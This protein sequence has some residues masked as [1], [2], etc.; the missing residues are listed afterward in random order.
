MLILLS[1]TRKKLLWLWIGFTA[2]LIVLLFVQTVAGKFENIETAVWT[3]AFAHLLPALALLFV[4]VLLNRNPS[5]VLFQATFRAVYAGA[6]AYLLLLLLTLLA[7][8]FATQNWSIE[9]YFARSYTW[10]MPF[11]AVLLLAFSFLY[12]RKE[13]LF[14]PNAAI[15]QEYVAKKAEFARRAGNV[16]QVQAFDLLI[17]GGGPGAALEYLRSQLK[18]DANEVLVLQNQYANWQKQRDLDLLPPDALQRELNRMTMAA[19]DCVEKLP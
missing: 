12:F 2:A 1:D 11:Q 3:W 5:K 6:A 8:P 7:L 4:A 10:L 13:P 9:E 18:T 14:R 17:S 19:I 16:S 15:M